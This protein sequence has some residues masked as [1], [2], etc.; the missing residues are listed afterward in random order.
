MRAIA[1]LLVGLIAGGAARL[2]VGGRD[3]IGAVGIVVLALA[4]A[5]IGGLVGNLTVGAR[6]ISTAG[7]IGSVI[8]AIGS[9]VAYRAASGRRAA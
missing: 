7:L 3:E 6:E 8:G 5:V 2:I 4:G 9:L 1:W